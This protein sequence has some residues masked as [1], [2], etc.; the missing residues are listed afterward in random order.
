MDALSCFFNAPPQLGVEDAIVVALLAFTAHALISSI[1]G[2][3]AEE[4]WQFL[5][6]VLAILFFPWSFSGRC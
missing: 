5:K 6:I 2:L 4:R 1:R 3:T